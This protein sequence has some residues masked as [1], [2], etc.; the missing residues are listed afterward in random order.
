MA[1]TKKHRRL[2]PKARRLKQKESTNAVHLASE[3]TAWLVEN[4]LWGDSYISDRQLGREPDGALHF[5]TEGPFY[6]LIN[7]YYEGPEVDRLT[8]EFSALLHKHGYWWDMLT[9]YHLI[10]IRYDQL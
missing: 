1:A 8:N 9:D 10:L 6:S 5:V 7:G 4:E 3:L 2:T